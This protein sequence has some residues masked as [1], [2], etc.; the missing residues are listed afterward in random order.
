MKNTR[1]NLV[2]V[3]LQKKQIESSNKNEQKRQIN[4]FVINFVYM[5]WFF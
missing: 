4:Y 2:Y 1:K 5:P 3:E